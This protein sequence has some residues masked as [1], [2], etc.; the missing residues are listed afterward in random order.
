[1]DNVDYQELLPGKAREMS[2]PFE[3]LGSPE[4]G[5]YFAPLGKRNNSKE[6]YLDN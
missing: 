6:Q 2:C 3:E 4:V 5:L 1:M